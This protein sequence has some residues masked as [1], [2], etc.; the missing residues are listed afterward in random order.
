MMNIL[1]GGRRPGV[2]GGGGGGGFC[3]EELLKMQAGCLQYHSWTACLPQ[4]EVPKVQYL[5]QR[6][7]LLCDKCMQ[8]SRNCTREVG[9]HAEQEII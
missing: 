5:P 7:T 8:A 4:Q 6:R 2:G 1:E 9:W 3:P